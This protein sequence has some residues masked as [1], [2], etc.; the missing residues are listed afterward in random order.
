MLTPTATPSSAVESHRDS[1]TAAIAGGV[2]GGVGGLVLLVLF[3]VAFLVR[4]R[5]K[6]LLAKERPPSVH[7]KPQLHSDDV[8]PDRK[9]LEGTRAARDMLERHPEEVAEM[10]T[11]EEVPSHDLNEMPSNETPGH[12]METTENEMAALDRMVR[13]M[14]SSTLV[15]SN[16]TDS[17]RAQQGSIVRAD[18]AEEER[19]KSGDVHT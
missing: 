19:R 7:E 2:G 12:E 13:T 14:P 16:P 6:R 5:R 11:N 8:K 17:D 1:H 10:P 4:R 18:Q 15:S 3:V 9:E